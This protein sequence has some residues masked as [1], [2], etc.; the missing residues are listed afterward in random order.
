MR[1]WV[2][3]AGDGTWYDIVREGH[4][5]IPIWQKNEPRFRLIQLCESKEAAIRY[6][7][8]NKLPC[9]NF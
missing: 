9:K 4:S 2:Y 1:W 3:L 7:K 8:D 6:I 5:G